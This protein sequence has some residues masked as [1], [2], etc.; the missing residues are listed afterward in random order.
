[1]HNSSSLTV[2]RT[3]PA[4]HPQRYGRSVAAPIPY[5]SWH[6]ARDRVLAALAAGDPEVVITG[7]SGTGK[8]AL[9]NELTG[10]L[11]ADGWAVST[12]LY[13]GVLTRPAAFTA[14]DLAAPAVSRPAVLLVDEADR[15]TESELQALQGQPGT[16]LVLAGLD[17]LR[18]RCAGR[19]HVALE[20]LAPNEAKT[21]VAL[22]LTLAGHP[23]TRLQPD[24]VARAAEL[25]GGTPRLLAQ[26][27]GAAVWLA[28]EDGAE[29]V[30]EAHVRSVAEFRS[31]GAIGPD[32]SEPPGP[33]GL[34]PPRSVSA[35]ETSL[36]AASLLAEAQPLPRG[37]PRRPLNAFA[38]A[39]TVLLVLTWPIHRQPSATLG[40]GAPSEPARIDLAALPGPV[41]QGPPQVGLAALEA[42][43]EARSDV[44]DEPVIAQPEAQPE[45]APAPAAASPALPS[46]AVAIA[47]AQETAPLPQKPA[48]TSPPARPVTMPAAMVSML[49]RRGNEMLALGDVSAARLLYGRAA[50]AGDTAAMVALGRTFEAGGTAARAPD[51][52]AAADWYGRAQAGGSAEA[53]TLLQNLERHR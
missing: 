35:Q 27:L 26:L 28:D 50:A 43:P 21:F 44:P 10:F 9:L 19:M 46:P 47:P 3:G 15:L 18:D 33:A 17:S 40:T 53:A 11:R 30:G 23:P 24:A 39:A 16:C 14:S 38:A 12:A 32:V 5:P 51:L 8:T 42:T 2:G 34:A 20:P 22:W 45:A 7:R 49:V 48:E 4:L 13:G 41:E 6:A 31:F 29:Q 37:R 25:S 1:L 52:V 36:P